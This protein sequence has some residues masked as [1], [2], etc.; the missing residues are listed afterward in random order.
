MPF[1]VIT[2]PD[3]AV[4]LEEMKA[5]LRVDHD[6]DDDRIEALVAGAQAGFEDPDI[7]WLR[8]PVARQEVEFF[9]DP[10]PLREVTLPGPVFLDDEH[11]LAV[12]YGANVEYPSAGYRLSGPLTWQPRLILN[13]GYSWPRPADEFRVRCW[14]GFASDDPRI[15]NFQSAIKLH[16]EM[17]YDDVDDAARYRTS[18]NALLSAYRFRQF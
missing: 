1:V 14:A 8:R 12:L 18:I 6:E 2:P 13:S 7:G 4:S 16:V 15:G 17:N 5:H 9:Y 3:Q 11:A 10:I